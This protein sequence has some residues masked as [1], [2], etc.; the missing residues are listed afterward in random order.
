MKKTHKTLKL[1]QYGIELR[2]SPQTFNNSTQK[3]TFLS[4]LLGVVIMHVNI[5]V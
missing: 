5:K 4:V 3:T 1:Q 2:E